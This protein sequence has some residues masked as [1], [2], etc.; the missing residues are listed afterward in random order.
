MEF[1]GR[2][3]YGSNPIPGLQVTDLMHFKTL[4]F[5][6]RLVCL[7]VRSFARVKDTETADPSVWSDLQWFA[8]TGEL[9]L[10]LVAE[11]PH[12]LPDDSAVCHQQYFLTGRRVPDQM[13]ATKI[14]YPAPDLFQ[15]FGTRWQET[16]VVLFVES[17]CFCRRSQIRQFLPLHHSV[18][19]LPQPLVDLYLLAAAKDL[20]SFQCTAEVGGENG[21]EA[22]SSSPE[23]SSQSPGLVTAHV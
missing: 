6:H 11:K 13:I 12:K 17:G 15:R 16:G 18:T 10:G 5:S 2:H 22:D 3:C 1:A 8:Q 20:T 19:P 21:V 14:L 7:S 9:A 4:H 23:V